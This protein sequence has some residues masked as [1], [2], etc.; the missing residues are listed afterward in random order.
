VTAVRTDA[1][2]RAEALLEVAAAVPDRIA[3]DD[4]TREATP[5]RDLPDVEFADVED[6]RTDSVLDRH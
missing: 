4:D 6:A 3:V 5:Q 1:D 2:A